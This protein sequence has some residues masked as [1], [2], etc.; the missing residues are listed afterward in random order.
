MCQLGEPGICYLNKEQLNYFLDVKSSKEN[1]STF[2]LFEL[3]TDID[4]LNDIS[5]DI[6]WLKQ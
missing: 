2:K 1:I 4:L 6:V 3:E 5:R